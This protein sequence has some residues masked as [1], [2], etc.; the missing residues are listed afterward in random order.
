MLLDLLLTSKSLLICA[1]HI[2]FPVDCMIGNNN[3]NDDSNSENI[4][5][6]AVFNHNIPLY[7]VFKLIYG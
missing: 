3:N 6:K 1:L 4:I 2:S 5:I 7:S